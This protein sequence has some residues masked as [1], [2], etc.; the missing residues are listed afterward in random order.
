MKDNDQTDNLAALIDAGMRSFKIEGRYKDVGYVKNVTAH[1]RRRLDSILDGRSDLRAASSGR[2][3]FHFTPDPARNFHRGQTDYFVH[4]RGGDVGAFDTPKYPGIAIGHVVR[5][6]PGFFEVL[7]E[8]GVGPLHNGDGLTYFDRQQELVGVLVNRATLLHAAAPARAGGSPAS[9]ST[10]R[11]EPN[12]PIDTLRDLRPDAPIARNRDMDWNRTLAGKTAERKIGVDW[13]LREESGRLLL[14]VADH[15]GHSVAV[16]APQDFAA[17]QHNERAAQSMRDCLAKLG[18]T[19]FRAA[20]IDM[21]WAT[22]RFIPA[23]AAN[24]W[25][26][27]AVAQLERLRL[28]CLPRLARRAPSQ[29]PAA[30]PGESLSYLGNVANQRAAAFYARHGVKLVEA[31]YEC[32]RELG[33]VSLMITKHCV[34]YSLSLCPKQAKGVPGVQGTIRAEPLTLINGRERLALHFDCKACEMHVVGRIKSGVLAAVAA[35]PVAFAANRRERPQL[36]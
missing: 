32:H 3:Q 31:G 23:G 15:E 4:G 25:R 30:Y 11:V 34:R 36:G 5:V 6:A 26:R 9:Q 24:A 19:I 10:W 22:P 20:Q 2:C 28:Q 1:Y 35:V 27:E 8:E 18:G 29:P 17:A 12:E 14:C 13:H 21:A 16:P 7:V 33:D